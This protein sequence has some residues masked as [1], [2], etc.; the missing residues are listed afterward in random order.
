MALIFL[1]CAAVLEVGGDALCRAG[2]RGSRVS[3]LMLGGIV[4]LLYGI[5]VNAPA[6][7]FGRLLGVYIA[8][9]F[10]VSQ[11]VAVGI[12]REPIS[13]PMLIGGALIVTGGLVLSCWP[14][15]TSSAVQAGIPM[16]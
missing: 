13:P 2:L 6:W 8:V 10:V 7:N 1:I 5:M 4:L 16:P 15:A 14:N 9:F 12:F 11:I 3:L